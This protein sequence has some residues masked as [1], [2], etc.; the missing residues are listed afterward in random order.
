MNATRLLTLSLCLLPPLVCAQEA[1]QPPG[2][3][4]KEKNP[5]EPVRMFLGDWVGE[6]KSPEEGSH[7]IALTGFLAVE[8]SIVMVQSRLVT[9]AKKRAEESMWIFTHDPAAPRL[10]CRRFVEDGVVTYDVAHKLEGTEIDKL[11]LTEVSREGVKGPSSGERW[12]ITYHQR[13]KRISF[14]RLRKMSIQASTLVRLPYRPG[15]RGPYA[16]T[17]AEVKIQRGNGKA[18]FNGQ[19]YHPQRDSG[20]EPPYPVVVFSPG[21]AATQVTGY[22]SF[23]QCFASWGFITVLVAF[24]DAPADERAKQFGE[25]VTW[26][27]AVNEQPDWELAR[28]FDLRRLVAAGHSRGGHAALLAAMNDQRFTTAMVFAPSGPKELKMQA[29]PSPLAVLG[30]HNPQDEPICDA[31]YTAAEGPKLHVSVKGMDHYLRP[32]SLHAGMM[33]YAVTYLLAMVKGDPKYQRWLGA[34]RE[35]GI[36]I[37][38]ERPLGGD[39]GGAAG[40]SGDSGGEPG[41]K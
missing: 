26:L 32:P 30:G 17:G 7:T 14:N 16:P 36:L 28:A 39:A 21:G 40:S 4:Q 22:E 31:L 25:V 1:P 27:S 18:A 38:F 24:G 12:V 15:L 2:A 37:R 34:A 23:G 10:R 6:G 33:K 35:D 3:P 19:I 8:K 5:L 29:L 13:L 9:D 20:I 11:T 41:G